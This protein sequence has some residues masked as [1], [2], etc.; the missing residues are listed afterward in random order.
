[1]SKKSGGGTLKVGR[2][3][4]RRK[5]KLG[6]EFKWP[7]RHLNE[8][9]NSKWKNFGGS[10]SERLLLLASGQSAAREPRL[11]GG[12]KLSGAHFQNKTTI[13][14][15]Y[16]SKRK[17]FFKKCATI[18]FLTINDGDTD[19]TWYH[20]ILV[21]S[22]NVDNRGGCLRSNA[23][24]GYVCAGGHQVILKTDFQRSTFF[25]QRNNYWILPLPTAGVIYGLT[26]KI[27]A[28][29][30]KDVALPGLV[31]LQSCEDATVQ[32]KMRP[33]T[34]LTCVYGEC[35]GVFLSIIKYSIYH[36]IFTCDNLLYS[37]IWLLC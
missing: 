26:C 3:K 10:D 4:E 7:R 28:I 32:S 36:K 35:Y 21:F 24:G 17:F 23:S 5:Q 8:H 14:W 13:Y 30:L 19:T 6:N 33:L 9:L 11:E 20:L 34:P 37:G 18:F 15:R 29:I 22:L 27:C 2:V 25:S 31:S 12:G 16:M 1:M